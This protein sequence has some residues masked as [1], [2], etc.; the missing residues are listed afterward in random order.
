MDKKTA[1][2]VVKIISILGYIG[3][4]FS[5]LAG[6]VMLFGGTFMASLLMSGTNYAAFVGALAVVIAIIMIVVGVLAIFVSKALWQHKNWARIVVVIFSALGVLSSLVS[7]MR[8][9]IV[10]LIIDGAILYFLAF[11]KTVIHLFK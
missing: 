11:D 6:I 7:I 3:A 4:A 9:G 5:I 8:G 2:L 1:E 10:G